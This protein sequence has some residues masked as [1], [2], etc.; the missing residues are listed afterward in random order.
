MPCASMLVGRRAI[1]RSSCTIGESDVTKYMSLPF[2]R[3]SAESR[4]FTKRI[5]RSTVI[6]TREGVSSSDS[7][8]PIV[9]RIIKFSAISDK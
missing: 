8:E 5:M 3:D 4:V 6:L 9:F 7:I 2:S 1:P